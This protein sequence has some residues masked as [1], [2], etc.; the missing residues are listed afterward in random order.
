M[1]LRSGGFCSIMMGIGLAVLLTA[2]PADSADSVVVSAGL[3][4]AASYMISNGDGT[5]SFQPSAQGLQSLSAGGINGNSYGNALGDFDNDGDLDYIMGGGDGRG[6]IY[7]FEGLGPGNQFRTPVPV[8]WWGFNEALYLMDMAVADFSGDGNLDFVI[9]FDNHQ[10]CSLYLGD[11]GLNFTYHSLDVTAPSTSTGADAADFNNDG[12]ADFVIAPGARDF[13]FYVNLGR[14]DGTFDTL[15][16]FSYNLTAYDGVAAADFDN[17]GHVDL[18]ACF[19][20]YLD[21]YLGQGNGS[22]TFSPSQRY[23]VGQYPNTALDN[24]D[25]DGDGNQD[26]VAASFGVAVYLGNGDGSFTFSSTL[27]SENS[28]QLWSVSAD[29]FIANSEPAAVAEFSSPQVFVGETLEF[30]GS[31]SS[32]EDG[33][34]VSY[35]WDFGDGSSGVGETVEHAYNDAG[36]YAVT[37]TV[38]DDRGATDSAAAEVA[39]VAPPPQKSAAI[40]LMPIA[41]KIKSRHGKLDFKGK[42]KKW[43]KAKIKLPEGYDARDIDLA[44]VCIFPTGDDTAV[45]FAYLDPKH[46]NKIHKTRKRHKST[47]NLTVKFNRQAVGDLIK[48][49][50]RQVNMKVTGYISHNGEALE[51]VGTGRLKIKV[52]KDAD[53]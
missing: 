7:L 47:R 30:F 19:S 33:Q 5:F 49:P 18:A 16:F 20:D 21:V 53:R 10:T 23:Y 41:A 45:E 32:D 35:D 42:K 6:Y 48:H 31:G 3:H 17:D 50:A 38:T 13:E 26:L 15:T 43:I 39:V 37:L 24:G 12:H 52:K 34:I 27:G 9:S 25:F 2:S 51:F 29:P 46:D 4:G 8:G 40:E 1:M 11:G 28:V 22:F 44:S 36:V 14:G